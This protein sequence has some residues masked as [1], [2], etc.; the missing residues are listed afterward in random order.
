MKHTNDKIIGSIIAKELSDATMLCIKA[1]QQLKYF[2]EITN[3]TTRSSR[4]TLV[5]CQLRLFLDSGGFLRCGGRIHNAS[6]SELAKF[7]YLLSPKHQITKLLVYAT[8]ERLHHAGVSSTITAIRQMYW[9]PTIRVYVRGDVK[10]D[11]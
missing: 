5:I 8:H 9:I 6:I 10:I 11:R 3:L 2:E 1:S 7:P 4:R